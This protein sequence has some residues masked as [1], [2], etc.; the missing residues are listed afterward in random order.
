M[1]EDKNKGKDTSQ[2][3]GKI[4]QK[5]DYIAEKMERPKPWPAAP[6]EGDT[7]YKKK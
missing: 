1:K 2:K 7:K 5:R 4:S 6:S 3:T